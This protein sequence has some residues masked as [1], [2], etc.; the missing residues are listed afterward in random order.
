MLLR[1]TKKAML[2]WFKENGGM[3]TVA[4]LLKC[5]KRE[6]VTES[7]FEIFEIL[8]GRALTKTSWFHS[9]VKWCQKLQHQM[10]GHAQR[11][12][13]P[14][15]NHTPRWSFTVIVVD[16]SYEKWEKECT[17][18]KVTMVTTKVDSKW[19]NYNG[20]YTTS[21][22]GQSEWGGWSKDGQKMFN[23]YVAMNKDAR[24]QKSTLVLESTCLNRLQNSQVQYYPPWL[25]STNQSSEI[26]Q[27]KEETSA[28]GDPARTWRMKR[29]SGLLLIICTAHAIP[30][31][32]KTKTLRPWSPC[33]VSSI[34][35]V[36][37][38]IND[39]PHNCNAIE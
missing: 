10:K 31:M 28:G 27:A 17:N 18:N 3:L 32:M 38:N 26:Q 39:M 6:I 5:L 37:F 16:N 15:H 13:K 11:C 22:A 20:C 34:S 21:D 9:V 7:D 1:S 33:P 35:V 8:L 24:Q 36:R 30:L 4:Q 23:K 25:Q 19:T 14:A 2:K 29:K 12:P